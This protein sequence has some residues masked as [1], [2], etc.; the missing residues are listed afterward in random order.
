MAQAPSLMATKRVETGTYT[1][2][3]VLVT[4]FGAFPGA[5]SNPTTAVLATIERERARLNRLGIVLRTVILPVVYDA[6]APALR[7]AVAEARPDV[8]LHLGLASRRRVVSVE[9][10]AVNRANP[11]H[12][13]AAR[14]RTAQ[15]LAAHGPARLPSTY[16]A[17]QVAAAARRTW[18]ATALSID[19]GDYLCNATLYRSLVER[20]APSAGFI[21]VPRL[22][23]PG[24]PCRRTRRSRPGL[25]DLT[26]VIFAALLVCGREARRGRGLVAR[27]DS[28]PE[29]ERP[30][31][32]PRGAASGRRP[33]P[34]LAPGAS[35]RAVSPG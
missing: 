34:P 18:P 35:D 17:A 29:R 4:G 33:P 15:S 26:R 23:D 20:L 3:T 22:R 8:I 25:R 32:R 7:A 27:P 6:V 21:H 16:P 12:P 19:A 9:T 24:Q 5:H 31:P 13:D 1:P 14:R 2:V 28:R 10:R 11:L 30:R